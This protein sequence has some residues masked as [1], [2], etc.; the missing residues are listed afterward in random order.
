MTSK[1]RVALERQLENQC[2]LYAE[3]FGFVHVK[4]DNAKRK[5]PDR[6]FLG[7]DGARLIVE[8]KR[9]GETARKQQENFHEEL[10]AMG[11]TVHLIDNFDDFTHLVVDAV[12]H[13]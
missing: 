13:C 2:C 3:A 7:P 6:L 4:L 8:F 10:A 9:A 11:H 1:S 12:K 5:W